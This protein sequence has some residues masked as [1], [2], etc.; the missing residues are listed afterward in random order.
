MYI[1]SGLYYKLIFS[2]DSAPTNGRVTNKTDA[3]MTIEWDAPAGN[4]GELG[5]Y[6]AIAGDRNHSGESPWKLS[7]LSSYTHYPVTIIAC[8]TADACGDGLELNAFT[9]PGSML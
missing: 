2:N 3:A 7:G 6:Q 1:F 5:N 4:G 9:K 8:N